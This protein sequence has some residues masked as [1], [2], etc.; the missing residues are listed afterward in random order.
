VDIHIFNNKGIRMKTFQV[1]EIYGKY[2]QM[3]LRDLHEGHYIIW[4]NTPGKRPLA[5]TLV[6]G[7]V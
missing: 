3:D 6:I 1:D 5:K 2:F 7:R 4:V